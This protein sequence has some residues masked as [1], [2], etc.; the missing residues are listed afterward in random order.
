MVPQSLVCSQYALVKM[1]SQGENVT[2]GFSLMK[3]SLLGFS[4]DENVTI[5]F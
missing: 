2:D 1:L 4:H 5:W 3:M